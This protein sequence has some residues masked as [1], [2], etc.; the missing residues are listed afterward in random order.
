VADHLPS[1]TAPS[2]T[3][4]E[5]DRLSG[6]TYLLTDCASHPTE[7]VTQ[8]DAFTDAHT[9]QGPRHTGLEFELST[10]VVPE[11]MHPVIAQDMMSFD[12]GSSTFNDYLDEVPAA[13]PDS[14]IPLPGCE[15]I[16]N[17]FY[18]PGSYQIAMGDLPF[19]SPGK[20]GF[21][22]H[23]PISWQNFA[24]QFGFEYSDTSS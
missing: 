13:Y 4:S 7:Y 5:L 12:M 18:S 24:E 3:P 16:F 20:N 17:N 23:H 19:T 11:N 14:S 21:E 10:D 9:P 1:H 2:F 6:K 15:A 22:T 8:P